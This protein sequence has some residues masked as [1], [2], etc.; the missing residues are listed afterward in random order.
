M[1]LAEASAR[2]EALKAEVRT[3]SETETLTEEQEARFEPALVETEAAVVEL[4]ALKLRASRVEAIKAIPTLERSAGHDAPG[5]INRTSPFA[6]DPENSTRSQRRDAAHAILET[7]GKHLTARQGDHL[8]KLL[9][10]GRGPNLDSD[11]IARLAIA[12]ESD[13]YKRAFYKGLTQVNPIFEP[14]EARAVTL[15]RAASE[16]TSALGG[17]GVPILIDPTIVLT[18]GAADAPLLNAATVVTITTDQWKGVVSAGLTFEY[19]AEAAVVADKT[20]TLAQPTIPVYRADGFIPYSVEIEQ[21]YPG[22]AEEMAHLLTQGYINLLAAG[23]M[24]SSGSSCPTGLFTALQRTGGKCADGTS[25]TGVTVTTLGTVG[26][27]DMRACWGS[28]GEL[29]RQHSTWVMNVTTENQVRAFGNNLALSDFTVDLSA[30]GESR[31]AG[32]PIILSDYAPSFTGTTGTSTQ[33][34]VLGD[35]SKF[36]IVQ[37]AGMVVEQVPHLFDQA[38]GRPNL[39]RGWLAW[40]R[41]GYNALSGN[42]F[43]TVTNGS[44]Y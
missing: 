42:P 39:S 30:P 5:Q 17:Y 34:T 41:H 37:R 32:R 9:R 23:T 21:D 31:L 1:N 6:V 29:F 43:R 40:T 2:V 16:G 3:L 19:T 24:T 33:I 38:T 26:A 7:N 8:D 13:A 22:F 10:S 14:D 44:S 12:T 18:S 20:P 27:V 15:F 11:V 25:G 4:D 28:L 35:L 36:M